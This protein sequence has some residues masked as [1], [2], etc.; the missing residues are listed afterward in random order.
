MLK[1]DLVTGVLACELLAR[2]VAQALRLLGAGLRRGPLRA[3][4]FMLPCLARL[5]RRDLRLALSLRR[6]RIIIL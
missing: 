4:H 1:L 3:V 2:V 6:P 5:V